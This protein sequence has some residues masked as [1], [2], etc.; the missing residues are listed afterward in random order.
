MVEAGERYRGWRAAARHAGS[1]RRRSRGRAAAR[2]GAVPAH[3]QRHRDRDAGARPLLDL[4][5]AHPE[6]RRARALAVAPGAAERGTII[7]DVLGS[8]AQDLS[9]RRCRPTAPGRA[10]AAW[11]GRIR[12]S[13]RPF[14]SSMRN[15]GRASSASR[16][17]FIA[18]GDRA[19]RR[20]SLD[21]HAEISGQLPIPLAG[22][23]RSSP[24]AARADR[25][26]HRR[27]GGFTH[28]RLQDR[29]A[30]EQPRGLCGLLAAAH[31]R[32]RDADARRLQGPADRD[33][34]ARAALHAHHRRAQ[35]HRGARDRADKCRDAA[36]RRDR[37]RASA[38][39]SR[40]CRPLREG[41]GGLPVAAVP[42]IRAPLL[43]LRP[44]CP[45]QGMVAARRRGGETQ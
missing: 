15:G 38:D 1:R 12:R 22:R 23:R 35:A 16:P 18:L 42:E 5:P 17:T 43:R 9:A 14:P 19:P 40:A 41:R 29:R 44:S 33:G 21:V 26:E 31:A 4:R 45:G 25:I 13:R 32:S 8:F 27:D 10:A 36:G 7:H 20:A 3:A 24:C 39:A 11:R 37:R 28:R 2:P 30:A 34:N 6:A